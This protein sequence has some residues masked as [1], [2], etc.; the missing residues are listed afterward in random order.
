MSVD[1]HSRGEK[2]NTVIK[3]AELLH[4]CF[5]N[6]KQSTYIDALS[7]RCVR[8]NAGVCRAG[9]VTVTV[10]TCNTSIPSSATMVVSQHQLMHA[11]HQYQRQP[12][13]M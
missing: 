2:S 4:K 1:A 10:Q 7:I 8:G 3:K 13:L 5:A 11:L 12:N 9:K 6:E